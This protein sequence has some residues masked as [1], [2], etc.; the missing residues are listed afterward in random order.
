MS[1]DE[2][3]IEALKLWWAENGTTLITSVAL[4]LVVLFGYRYW[5]SRSDDH[6]AL[7]S[8]LFTQMSDIVT[9][10]P[11][12]ELDA[13]AVAAATALNE[14]LREGFDDTAYARY[15]AL[16]MAKIHVDAGELAQ[17]EAELGWILDNPGIGMF[18]EVEQPLLM[19]ARGRLAR[20]ALAQGEPD[21]ALELVR[22]VEAG[23]FE[24]VY[25]E[26]EGDILMVQGQRDEARE[27]YRRA[28]DAG[29]SSALLQLK[30]NDLGD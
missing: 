30:F 26:I 3:Q 27:A 25:A 29:N 10:A 11:A 14:Q 22:A 1:T 5:Q 6:A 8:D 19:T 15:A 2:E 28:L 13:E 18:S 24:A 12:S 20:V 21:R 17:A 9:S 4:V 23:D 7:A 16:F